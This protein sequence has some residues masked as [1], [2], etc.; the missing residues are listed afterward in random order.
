MEQYSSKEDFEEKQPLLS[1]TV[2]NI[3]IRLGMQIDN[4]RKER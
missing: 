3:E 4:T 1:K 2:K